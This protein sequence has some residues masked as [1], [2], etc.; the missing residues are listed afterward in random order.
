MNDAVSHFE[1]R[2]PDLILVGDRPRPL[3]FVLTGKAMSNEDTSAL[4][5]KVESVLSK[6]GLSPSRLADALARARS[7]KTDGVP[8]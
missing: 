4:E 8:A 3:V 5:A 1:P 6:T 7:D 2:K